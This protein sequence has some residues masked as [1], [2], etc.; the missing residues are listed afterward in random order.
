MNIVNFIENHTDLDILSNQLDIFRK[1]ESVVSDN[2]IY[3]IGHRLIGMTTCISF[4]SAW[5]AYFTPN[6]K[7]IYISRNRSGYIYDCLRYFDNNVMI[8]YNNIEFQ[9]NS[10]IKVLSYNS[11]Y[12]G[13][14]AD[15]IMLD[16][17]SSI[18]DFDY[19]YETS[20]INFT[21]AK[22]IINSSYLSTIS[23]I[24]DTFTTYKYPWY[25]NDYLTLDWYNKKLNNLDYDTFGRMY[26]CTRGFSNE[27]R[28]F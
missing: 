11:N 14:K 17:A 4:Y 21:N 20:L 15:I 8:K 12:R 10:S 5:K 3:I 28:R 24:A 9:N 18:D 2:P 6:T 26:C 19:F 16:D 1:Y 25:T 7:I 22:I 27:R 23:S 13:Y